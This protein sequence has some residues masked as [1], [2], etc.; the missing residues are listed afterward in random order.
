MTVS[1]NLLQEPWIPCVAQDGHVEN[2]NLRDALVQAHAWRELGGDSPLVTASLYRLLLAVLHRVYGPN[3]RDAWRVLWA[4]GRWDPAA[5]DAY[6]H[7]WRERFDLFDTAHPFFQAHDARVKPRWAGDLVHETR[8]ADTLFDHM[9]QPE[10]LAWSPDRAARYVVTMQT[11]G[12]AGT[13]GASMNFTD[14]PS[15][16]SITFLAT[17]SSLFHTLMLNMLRYPTRDDILPHTLDDRPCWEA[18][19]PFLPARQVPLGYLDY[20]TWPNRYLELHTGASD[21]LTVRAV[22]MGPGLRLSADIRNPFVAYQATKKGGYRPVSWEADRALW[23]DAGAVLPRVGGIPPR[24]LDYIGEMED[25]LA[26]QGM[27]RLPLGAY[28]MCT[29]KGKDKVH[30]YRGEH[31]PLGLKLLRSRDLCDHLQAALVEA[32][33]VGQCLESV[34]KSK[35]YGAM[36]T[37]A[38]Y[39]LCPFQDAKDGRTPDDKDVQYLVRSWGAARRYWAALEVPFYELLA[40]LEAPDPLAARAVWARHLRR[41]AYGAL[42][43]V[44]AG[45]PEDTASLKAAVLA[46][47]QLGAGL[48]KVL[49]EMEMAVEGSEVS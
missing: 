7:R 18:D 38:S 45:L 13:K 24:Q 20:L 4:A 44:I 19:D 5:L 34:G 8:A 31:M 21:A 37:L 1:Y 35:A 29:E 47:G 43:A 48:A 11:Y 27:Y 32:E 14:S 39:V 41:S 9:N 42:E 33:A 15:T 28:G 12:F 36:A 26:A 17:G 22:S 25:V 49:P 6:L 3:D 10:G 23:R 16:R 2:L 40:G 46:R 30:F